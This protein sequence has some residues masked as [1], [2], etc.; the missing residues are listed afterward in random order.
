MFALRACGLGLIC[1]I[2]LDVRKDIQPAKLARSVLHSE[3][4][5]RLTSIRLRPT[6]LSSVWLPHSQLWVVFGVIALTGVFY[7]FLTRESG[8]GM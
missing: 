1:S 7:Q 8:G 3:F 2:R 6:F 5:T 4:T